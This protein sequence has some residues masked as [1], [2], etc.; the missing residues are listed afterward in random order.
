MYA[1]RKR[2]PLRAGVWLTLTLAVSLVVC[3]VSFKMTA[4][5]QDSGEAVVEQETVAE[6]TTEAFVLYDIPLDDDLQ[7]HIW[8]ECQERG[9]PYEVIL[10][11][12]RKESNY[13][14]DVVG[15]Y[16]RSVGLMQ[17]QSRWHKERMEY[18][19]CW[20]LMDP[21]ANVTVGIDIFAEIFAEYQDVEKALMVYNA[22]ATGARTMWFD[23]GIYSSE[24]SRA[25]LAYVDE[26]TPKTAGS[27]RPVCDGC[28]SPIQGD[29]KYVIGGEEFCEFC[30]IS[31]FRQEIP[32]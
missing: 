26:L 8:E 30:L 1:S 28:T 7:R 16:G 9:A 15:D 20:S 22:G 31:R 17:I 14:T 3:A 24:Y 25:V 32:G 12:I 5:A 10:A 21:Y 18:L 6:E 27:D 29:Y 2:E 19:G 23:K 4:C 11:V 13:E